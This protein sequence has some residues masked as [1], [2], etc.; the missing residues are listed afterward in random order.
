MPTAVQSTSKSPEVDPLEA[1][2]WS[3]AC[4]LTGDRERATSVLS[5]VLERAERPGRRGRGAPMGQA[6]L[7]RA[8][9]V[10]LRGA[11]PSSTPPFDVARHEMAAELWRRLVA[12]PRRERLAWT[13]DRVGDLAGRDAHGAFV[14][15]A[16]DAGAVRELAAS[17]QNQLAVDD[18]RGAEALRA[19]LRPGPS[20]GI[21]QALQAMRSGARRKWRRSGAW[22]VLA[23]LA[24]TIV[25]GWIMIDLVARDDEDA[26]Q[27]EAFDRA[28]REYSN[29]MSPE[30]A[31]DE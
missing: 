13:I 11:V 16:D 24:F 20:D 27:R 29:L 28:Q 12:L 31:Q 15:G 4:A 9:A 3:F 17:A 2:L 1:Q 30:E 21:A 26:R 6:R 22:L 25:F 18:V 5:S 19:A 14:L 10:A 8:I 23:F 7:L